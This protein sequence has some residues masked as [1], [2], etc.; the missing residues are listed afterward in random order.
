MGS[1][2][3]QVYDPKLDMVRYAQSLRLDLNNSYNYNMNS[4]DLSGQIWM[5]YQVYH[6]MR[7]YKWWW[8]IFFWGH[9][10]ILVNV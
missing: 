1:E 5:V 7:K 10:L 6:W 8:L 4:V 2:T 9:D 3:H